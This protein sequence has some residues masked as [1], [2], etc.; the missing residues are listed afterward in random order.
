MMLIITS[1]MGSPKAIVL[2]NGKRKSGKDYFASSLRDTLSFSSQIIHLSN[3]IKREYATLHNLDYEELLTDSPYK[4]KYRKE[5]IALG[6]SRRNEDP[7]YY[8][9]LATQHATADIWIIVDNRRETDI[10]YFKTNYPQKCLVIRVTADESVRINRGWSY[11]TGV[12]DVVSECGLD[13][14]PHDIVIV[15][16]GSGSDNFPEKLTAVVEWCNGIAS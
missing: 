5:M 1:A 12:D 15:N 8:C 11:K 16:D 10:K 2:V 4:D 3:E 7:S 13:E 9:H 6:E 14:Y